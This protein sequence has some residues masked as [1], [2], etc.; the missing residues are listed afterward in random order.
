MSHVE[1]RLPAGSK[2]LSLAYAVS[3]TSWAVSSQAW[4]SFVTFRII[5]VTAPA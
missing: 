3:N 1:N 5:R 2:I 4:L